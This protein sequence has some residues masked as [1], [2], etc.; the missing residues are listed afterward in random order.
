VPQQ[1]TILLAEPDAP[2]RE[3]WRSG[4]A[5]MGFHVR[6]SADAGSALSMAMRSQVDL[7][8]TE[9]YLPTP[10]DRCLVRATRREAALR[11][12]KILVVSDHATADDRNWA[13]S[14]GADAYL[15]KPVRLGRML[16]VA[17]RLAMSR[18]RSRGE[19]RAHE[20]RSRAE[21]SRAASAG[22][23]RDDVQG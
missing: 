10:A 17:G 16:Q 12:M 13:L 3:A 5:A 11:H 2:L 21:E 15:V 19:V 18:E 20:T 23:H 22:G 6:E 14:A 9:L 1:R 8:V 7:L 4:L